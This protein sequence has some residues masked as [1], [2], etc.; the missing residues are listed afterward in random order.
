MARDVDETKRRARRVGLWLTAAVLAMFAL[1]VV[2]TWL[3]RL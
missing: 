3:H 1:P 2:W